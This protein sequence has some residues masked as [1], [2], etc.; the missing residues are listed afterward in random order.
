V[1]AVEGQAVFIA[2]E[3]REMSV[4]DIARNLGIPESTVWSQLQEARR[5]FTNALKKHRAI[6]AFM[7]ARKR[8]RR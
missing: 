2:Y 8:G 4:R 6:E 5:E 7:S 3:I 1:I